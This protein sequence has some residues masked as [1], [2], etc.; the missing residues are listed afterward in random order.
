MISQIKPKNV[1]E[2]LEDES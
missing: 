1:N 2:A